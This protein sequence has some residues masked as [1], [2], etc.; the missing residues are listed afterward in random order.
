MDTSTTRKILFT[1]CIMQPNEMH[2]FLYIETFFNRT[3]YVKYTEMIST[4][5]NSKAPSK[6]PACAILWASILPQRD[7]Q[8]CQLFQDATWRS[9]SCEQ[10]PGWGRQISQVQKCKKGDSSWCKREGG[11][12][13]ITLL[14]AQDKRWH[15]WTCKCLKTTLN[16]PSTCHECFII[17]PNVQTI[18]AFLQK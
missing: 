17:K 15:I 11:R 8:C 2:D 14:I 5:Q 7:E 16:A 13:G 6:Q 9:Q 10:N 18:L 4:S 1:Q 3:M 12:L